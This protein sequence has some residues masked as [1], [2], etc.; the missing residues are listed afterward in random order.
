MGKM[1]DKVTAD[2]DEEQEWPEQRPP[3]TA[4]DRPINTI[5]DVQ[6][7]STTVQRSLYIPHHQ[8]QFNQN[9]P[10][11]IGP[12]LPSIISLLGQ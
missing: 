10:N 7:K 1:K 11:S 3:T 2:T 4:F 8:R 5:H 9:S 6:S 12:D